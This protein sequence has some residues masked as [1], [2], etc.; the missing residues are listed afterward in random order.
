[1]ERSGA[2]TFKGG[3][4][5]LIG[6]EPEVGAAAPDFRVVDGDLNPVTLSDLKG[7]ATLI[8][9]VPSLDTPVCEIQTKRFNEEA[10]GLGLRVLTVSLDLPFAQGRFCAAHKVEGV[11][12]LS[13]YQSRSF[14][15]AWGLLI[16]ELCLLA[17]AVFV[18]DADGKITYKQ[19]VKEVTDQPD[20]DTALAEARKVA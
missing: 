13:D 16:K 11:Q 15:E 14:G 9:V 2:I 12:C 4:L 6:S 3:P 1:M 5:T 8:S 20:Y 18:L 10:A 7:R 19:I 17:R